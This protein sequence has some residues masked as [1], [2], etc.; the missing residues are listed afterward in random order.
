MKTYTSQW[1]VKKIIKML[2]KGEISLNHTFQ[3]NFIWTKKQASLLIQTMMIEYP[4]PPLYAAKNADGVFEIFEGKQRVSSIASYLKNEFALSGCPNVPMPDGTELKVNGKKFE[5][6]PEELQDKI[7]DTA[8]TSFYV[9]DATKDQVADMMWRLNNGK[10]LSGIE[11]TRI[12]ANNLSVVHDLGQNELFLQSMSPAALEKYHNEDVV[13]K[14]YMALYVENPS[15]TAKMV[16]ACAETLE[17]TEDQIAELNTAFG[18]IFE[19]FKILNERGQE[20]TAKKIVLR[21]HLLSIIKVALESAQQGVAAEKFA[22]WCAYYFPGDKDQVSIDEEYNK[23]TVS[24][25]TRPN[26]VAA[27]FAAV[28]A[29]Y[30]QYLT[31]NP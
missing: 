4:V 26:Y 27:R 23:H 15:F 9:E 14:A 24:A 19:A 6:L 2:D 8:L 11:L 5:N 20:N 1:T 25:V 7:F 13:L 17:I 10:P 30:H 18:R 29:S 16:R 28:D 3:R 31:E 22:D 21:T 12:K